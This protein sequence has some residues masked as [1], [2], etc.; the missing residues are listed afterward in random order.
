MRGRVGGAIITEAEATETACGSS[1][2]HC[3]KAALYSHRNKKSKVHIDNRDKLFERDPLIK[4]F[5][6]TNKVLTSE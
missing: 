1:Q 3:E 6:G 2:I 4:N 5:T